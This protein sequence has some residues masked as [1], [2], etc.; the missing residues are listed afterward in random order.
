MQDPRSTD[1]SVPAR[2]VEAVFGGRTV[3][4]NRIG[5]R[6]RE[7]SYMPE[8]TAS[9][10]TIATNPRRNGRFARTLEMLRRPRL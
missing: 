4:V 8:T 9:M 1:G 10:A 3:T 5:S 7:S 2:P 6:Q